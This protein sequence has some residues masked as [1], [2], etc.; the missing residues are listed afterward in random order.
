MLTTCRLARAPPRAQP[1]VSGTLDTIPS[2]D[3][4]T[5]TSAAATKYA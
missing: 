5:A 1:R 2:D 4:V 3:A